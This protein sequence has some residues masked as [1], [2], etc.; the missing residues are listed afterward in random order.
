[1]FWVIYLVGECEGL[2][3]KCLKLKL[4][5]MQTNHSVASSCDF[6]K[7]SFFVV[8]TDCGRVISALDRM[9][10][11]PMLSSFNITIELLDGGEKS[12]NGGEH[13]VGSQLAVVCFFLKK[14]RF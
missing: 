8:Q 4:Y 2:Q 10:H 3:A 1:M 9:S 12:Q 5:H 13:R 6:V 11:H 7:E 14:C